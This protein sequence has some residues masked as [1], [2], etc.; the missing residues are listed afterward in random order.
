LL[1]KS[2]AFGWFV[3]LATFATFLVY[4]I[5]QGI[6]AYTVTAD[7]VGLYALAVALAEGLRLVPASISDVFLSHL[8]NELSGRQKQVPLVFRCT[9]VVSVASM[10]L[11]GLVGVP[12]ILVL[13]GREYGGTIVPFFILLPGVAALGGARILASDL[14]ARGKPQYSTGNSFVLLVFAIVLNLWLIPMLGIAGAALASSISYLIS[15]FMW[16]VYY[17]RESGMRLPMLVPTSADIAVV[18][19]SGME[20]A[21]HYV[22]AT[23][24]ARQRFVRG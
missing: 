14:L 12:V 8:A 9:M 23:W 5:G 6:L 1:R 16:T 3:S 7:Q 20:I 21:S 18:W 10:L 4:R 13:F 19:K 24:S 22:R 2:L 17:R 15:T 11:A